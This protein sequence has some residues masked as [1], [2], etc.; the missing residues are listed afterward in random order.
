MSEQECRRAEEDVFGADVAQFEA[1]LGGEGGQE[2]A[3]NL[4]LNE[5]LERC[6]HV[7][8]IPSQH[9]VGQIEAGHKVGIGAAEGAADLVG[10][11]V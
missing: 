1:G 3:M 6:A 8:D 11:G 2:T 7:N 4:F 5:L 10:D 9:D